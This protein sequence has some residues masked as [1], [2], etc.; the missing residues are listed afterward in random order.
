MTLDA[1]NLELTT[2][3]GT[4]AEVKAV[5]EVLVGAHDYSLIISGEAPTMQDAQDI[6]TSL[7]PGIPRS[8]KQV[9]GIWLGADMI[10]LADVI[11]GYPAKDHAYIGLLLI[12]APFRHRGIGSG[13]LREIERLAKTWQCNHLRLSVVEANRDAAGFW[14]RWG[15][16]DTGVRVPYE[17]GKVISQSMIFEKN[18]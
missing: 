11:Q 12:A 5:H 7:P 4:A 13:C 2:L 16:V 14:T 8:R 3:T 18:L 17:C 6:F 15:F 10:G 1:S 9:L